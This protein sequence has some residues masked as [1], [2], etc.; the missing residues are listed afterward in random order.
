MKKFKLKIYFDNKIYNLN[1]LKGEQ[2]DVITE[3][4]DKLGFKWELV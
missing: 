4:L 2:V 1:H 3:I